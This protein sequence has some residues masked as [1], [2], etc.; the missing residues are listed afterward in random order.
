MSKETGA[1]AGTESPVMEEGLVGLST[2]FA[3]QENA[4][5]LMTADRLGRGDDDLGRVLVKSFLYTLSQAD[6]IPKTVIFLNSGVKLACEGSETLQSL[7]ALQERGAE[8]LSCGT[9]LDFFRLKDKLV[10]GKVSNMY[11]IVD[12]LNRSS[13]VVTL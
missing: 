9:C 13:H 3:V 4:L 11:A 7:L 8:I 2:T 10:A 1:A 6:M 5:L 12:M